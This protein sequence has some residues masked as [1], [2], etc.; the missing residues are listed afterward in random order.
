[1][2]RAQAVSIRSNP[3]LSIRRRVPRRGHHDHKW[4]V[5]LHAHPRPYRRL[6]LSASCEL[7]TKYIQVTRHVLHTGGSLDEP[8]SRG[9]GVMGKPVRFHGQACQVS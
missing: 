8:S 6:D 3:S 2:R 4:G 7:F 9:L 1:M 5:T